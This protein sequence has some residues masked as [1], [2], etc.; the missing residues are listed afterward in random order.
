MR[1]NSQ[2]SDAS[3]AKNA[4]SQRNN[5]AKKHAIKNDQGVSP[6]I[7]VILMVA[8]TVILA[9]VIAA[10]V[11]GMSGNIDKTKIVSV[12]SERL[13]K[14]A[15]I[16]YVEGG[17]DTDQLFSLNVTSN[18]VDV[19]AISDPTVGSSLIFNLTNNP[20]ENRIVAIG[21]FLDGKEQTLLK[22][23]L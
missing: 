23:N 2:H 20:G 22:T 15:G 21:K 10:F 4:E 6:V 16:I 18:G 12:T 11:F 19:G 1:K 13:N 3:K 17:Q 7:G 14:T 9:A 8:I 5:A